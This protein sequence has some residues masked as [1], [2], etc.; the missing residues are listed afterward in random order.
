LQKASG[1]L[2]ANTVRVIDSLLQWY[3]LVNSF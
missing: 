2:S 1:N 3:S